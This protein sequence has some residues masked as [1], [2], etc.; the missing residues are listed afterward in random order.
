MAVQ[1]YSSESTNIKTLLQVLG[2]KKFHKKHFD[3]KWS[4]ESLAEDHTFLEEAHPWYKS[5]YVHV[6]V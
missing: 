4:S 1:F 5:C 2:K 6:E 3:T